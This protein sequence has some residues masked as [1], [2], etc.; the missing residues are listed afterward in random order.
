MLLS[1][2]PKGIE[3]VKWVAGEGALH[4]VQS[5]VSAKEAVII[6]TEPK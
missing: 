5:Y 1:E 6:W 3:S 4:P 2:L